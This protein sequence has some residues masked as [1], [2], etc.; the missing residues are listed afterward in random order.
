MELLEST[1]E[2]RVFKNLKRMCDFFKVTFLFCLSVLLAPC[3]NAQNSKDQF[4]I[5]GRVIDSLSGEPVS[6]AT[7]IL[8]PWNVYAVADEDGKFTLPRVA[9]GN[10]NLSVSCL[11]YSDYQLSLNLK[12]S[13]NLKIKVTQQS[14]DLNEVNI[15]ATRKVGGEKIKFD[16]VAIEYV[17]PTSLH[18][19]F[20]LLPGSVYVENPLSNFQPISMRQAGSDPNTSLGVSVM[21]DGVPFTNDGMRTQLIGVTQNSANRGDGEINSRSG[22]NQGVDL[23]YISTD[24]IESVEFTRGI[25]SAKHGN[26]SSGM[27]QINSKKGESPLRIRV[28]G[29]LRNQLVYAGK[30]FK[31]RDNRGTINV[32]VDYL[33]AIDDVREEMD[34]FSRLTAQV[35]YNRLWTQKDGQFELDM[36]LNQTITTSKMKKDEL[37]YEYNESYRADYSKSGFMLKGVLTRNRGWLNRLDITSSVDLVHD[38]ISRHMMVLSSSGPLSSPMATEAGEHEGAY[39]PGKY[40]SDFYIENIPI[41]FY[42]QV[43]ALTRI[44]MTSKFFVNLDYGLDLIATKN[45]GDGAVI[46]DPT[47]PPF[48]Y[49]NTYMRPRSNKDIPALVNGAA[50]FQSNWIYMPGADVLKLSAGARLTQMFNLPS[51]YD[52]RGKS[53]VDPRVNL[54]YTFKTNTARIRINHG[55]RLGYGVES[56]LPTLD[57]LYPEK[58]YKDFYMLNS[59]GNDEQYRRLITYTHIFDVSNPAIKPN[60]NEKFEAG[61]DLELGGFG[62]SLTA[63]YEKSNTGFEYYNSYLPLSYDLYSEL[64]PGVDISN[65]KPSKD[66]YVKRDYNIFTTTSQVNNSKTVEKQ[67][68]E[69]RL[70]FPKIDKLYT[71]IEVN[72]AYYNTDYGTTMPMQYYPNKVIADVPYRYMGIY[73]NYPA[74]RYKRLNTNVWFNTHIPQFGLMFTNFFQIIWIQSEQYYDQRAVYPSSLMGVDGNITPLTAAQRQLIENRDPEM[75]YLKR[76]I[77]PLDYALNPEPI[78]LMW[79]IKAT[80]EFNKYAKLSFFVNNIIDISP[81]YRTGGLKTDRKWVTPYFGLELFVNIY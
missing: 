25:A 77:T 58:V 41:N 17:Q 70:V 38:N 56:K 68:I 59:Y 29:D 47:R 67:G 37:T 78:T 69:Y 23:R 22:M 16:Q 8:D 43:N 62:L 81:I 63:F 57:Y 40:Y 52:L 73:D 4:L 24:H 3:L 72:G 27:I 28:K 50:Y 66:D 39:L 65:R 10:C 74:N 36:R 46:E 26:L 21:A 20:V 44:Q 35:Y 48:P 9:G 49:D 53:I 14:F 61:Y 7:V 31:L 60:K 30:G 15:M 11:G 45:V 6:Y 64:K 42:L 19:I 79:N 2:E 80:K 51:G 34:K 71:Q 13:V 5:T 55:L 18:D 32:G 1:G 12:S 75:L 33:N 76:S 54:S